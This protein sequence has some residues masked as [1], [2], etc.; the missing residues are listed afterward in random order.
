MNSLVPFPLFHNLC[1]KALAHGE[2]RVGKRIFEE[3]TLIFAFAGCSVFPQGPWQV[4]IF[5]SRLWCI[6]SSTELVTEGHVYLGVEGVKRDICD[7][8][9]LASNCLTPG[10]SDLKPQFFSAHSR[11]RKAAKTPSFSSPHASN[12][13]FGKSFCFSLPLPWAAPS[14]SRLRWLQAWNLEP[15]CLNSSSHFASV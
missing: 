5:A 8:T 6:D 11:V 1:G 12:F 4:L 10:L 3:T 9:E 13:P 7:A 2:G 15:K 14:K